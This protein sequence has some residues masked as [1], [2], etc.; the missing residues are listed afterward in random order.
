MKLVN[1]LS[2]LMIPLFLSGC[3][4]KNN[5]NSASKRK[6]VFKTIKIVPTYQESYIGHFLCINR[7]EE[8]IKFYGWE[9]LKNGKFNPIPATIHYEVEMD[10]EWN[11]LDQGFYS[12]IPEVFTLKSK[13]HVELIVKLGYLDRFKNKGESLK[14]RIKY[15]GFAS[16]SFVLDW[17]KDRR[18][19]I[20]EALRKEHIDK[21][22][23]LLF[24]AGFKSELIQGDDFSQ[25]LRQ[26]LISVADDNKFGFEPFQGDLDFPPYIDSKGNISYGFCS[27]NAGREYEYQYVCWLDINPSKFNPSWFRENYQNHIIIGKWGK[28]RNMKFD[29]NY[30]HPMRGDSGINIEIHYFPLISS[31]LPDEEASREFFIKI[32]ENLDSW[33]KE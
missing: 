30:G 15:Y 9:P 16:E 22:R 14:A 29:A 18:D 32:L 33:L 28:G 8:N 6:I 5:S 23:D 7:T 13:N 19:G 12:G 31:S 25:R 17:D 26:S 4:D 27:S 20:F 11:E 10:G 24:Q 1:I 21:V 2:I 3:N